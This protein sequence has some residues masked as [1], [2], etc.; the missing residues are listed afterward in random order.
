M[1]KKTQLTTLVSFGTTVCLVAGF[2]LL[3]AVPSRTMAIDIDPTTTNHIDVRGA[4]AFKYDLYFG[5][6]RGKPKKPTRM[7]AKD[8]QLLT[9][10]GG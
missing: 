7:G 6:D 2:Y 10:Y 3:S 5:D 4:A 9:Y 8:E 1:K